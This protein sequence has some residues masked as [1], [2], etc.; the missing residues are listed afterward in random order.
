VAAQCRTMRPRPCLRLRSRPLR[1]LYFSCYSTGPMPVQYLEMDLFIYNATYQIWICIDYRYAVTPRQFNTHLRSHHR[2]H[3]AARTAEHRQAA[4][5]EILKQPWIEPTREPCKF[6]PPDSAPIPGLPVYPSLRCP[7]CSYMSR[8]LATLRKHLERIHPETRRP[9]G[10]AFKAK[11][12]IAATAESV[13][14]QRFF[15]YGPESSFFIMIPPSPIRQ[16][17]LA[18]TM[19]EAEFIQA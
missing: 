11:P 2:H 15:V 19:S 6:P 1:F 18:S 5:A 4:L 3:P 12:D 8:S 9:R 14:C 7:C 13:S 16:Q 10:R 17:R